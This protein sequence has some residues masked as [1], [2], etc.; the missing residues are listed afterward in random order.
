MIGP[1]RQPVQVLRRRRSAAAMQLLAPKRA[2]MSAYGT[3][4]TNSMGAVMSA[5]DP[6]RTLRARSIDREHKALCSIEEK[7]TRYSVP[8]SYMLSGK[9]WG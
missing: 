6:E 1:V 3:K 9:H 4:R 8:R 7:E 5:S 2:A